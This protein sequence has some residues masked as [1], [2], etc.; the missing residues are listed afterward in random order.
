MN[1]PNLEW[2]EEI[3]SL[4]AGPKPMLDWLN[5]NMDCP[6]TWGNEHMKL[7]RYWYMFHL[8]ATNGGLECW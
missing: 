4:L 5:Q 1:K 3:R 8:V 6:I 2:V 7:P